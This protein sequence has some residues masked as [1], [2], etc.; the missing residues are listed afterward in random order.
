MDEYALP[1]QIQGVQQPNWVYK[2]RN[3]LKSLSVEER[4]S[5]LTGDPAFAFDPVPYQVVYNYSYADAV[6][7]VPALRAPAPAPAPQPV[8][9][10]LPPAP[11]ALPPAILIAPPPA[12]LPVV[13]QPAQVQAHPPPPAPV[14]PAPAILTA[15]ATLPTPE[16]T[17]IVKEEPQQQAPKPGPSKPN[18][19]AALSKIRLQGFGPEDLAQAAAFKQDLEERERQAEEAA[20]AIQRS[21]QFRERI[22]NRIASSSS[23]SGSDSNYNTPPGSPDIPT[24]KTKGKLKK[25]IDQVTNA[26]GFS[27]TS[28]RVTRASIRKKEGTGWP[29]KS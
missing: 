17:P 20:K 15:P 19:F 1:K 5:I 26:L 22:R 25:N 14:L 12:P 8:P 21:A 4:N 3:F 11:R 18:T 13:P 6:R 27:F 10:Q 28:N 9:A 2:R 7:Q 23:E 29:P 16:P 24:T